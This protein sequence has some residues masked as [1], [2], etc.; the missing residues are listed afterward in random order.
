MTDP[1]LSDMQ[2]KHEA[3]VLDHVMKE[4]SRWELLNSRRAAFDR[5]RLSPTL[6][7]DTRHRATVAVHDPAAAKEWKLTRYVTSDGEPIADPTFDPRRPD[8]FAAQ[9]AEHRDLWIVAPGG[10]TPRGHRVVATLDAVSNA[11]EAIARRNGTAMVARHALDSNPGGTFDDDALLQLGRHESGMMRV[12]DTDVRGQVRMRT[13]LV[14]KPADAAAESA[15]WLD[16]LLAGEKFPEDVRKLARST[17]AKAVESGDLKPLSRVV[18]HLSFV[19]DPDDNVVPYARLLMWEP[20]TALP[21]E[22]KGITLAKLYGAARAR[23]AMA[24]VHGAA[25][26]EVYFRSPFG[27]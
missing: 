7:T 15:Y 17:V 12:Y 13:V 10:V 14:E 2:A 18:A 19:R 26:A 8:E 3:A 23:A 4:E 21:T 22:G 27:A 6:D 1:I 24:N 9:L 5:I 16:K 11:A 25:N 20:G